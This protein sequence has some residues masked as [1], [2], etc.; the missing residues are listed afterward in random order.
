MP[1]TPT[2]GKHYSTFH[3]YEF[4]YHISG[5]LQYLSFSVWLISFSIMSSRFI[6]VVACFRNSFLLKANIPLYVYTHFVYTFIC[7]WTCELFP[8]FG[9]VNNTALIIGVQLSVQVS[10]FNYCGYIRRSGVAGS[11]V[12]T[13]AC[14][15]SLVAASRGY[16]SL[17]CAG[18]SLWW[19]LLLQ[20]TGSRCTG[21]SSCGMWAQQLWLRDQGSNPCALHWQADS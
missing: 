18:F 13:A 10:A 6:H 11:N 15:L 12:F 3:F 16:S 1:P 4:D 19:L 7:Q 17:R 9:Y 21:F 2:P 20:S 14:G 5:T 8:S